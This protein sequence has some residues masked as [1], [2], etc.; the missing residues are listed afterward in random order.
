MKNCPS[1]Q[2]G[3]L[4]AGVE[5]VVQHFLVGPHAETKLAVLPHLARLAAFAGRRDTADVLLPSLLTFFNSQSWQ[6]GRGGCRVGEGLAGCRELACLWHAPSPAHP[7]L[8]THPPQCPP[9][10]V[11]AAFY[12]AFVGVCP[13][14]G[15]EGVAAI[16]LPFLDR[17]VGDP[18]PAVVAEAIQ[19]LA[20]ICSDGLLRKRHILLVAARLCIRPVL[21]PAAPTPVRAAAV[22]FL[23]A[24]AGQLSAAD[25]QA[26]LLPLA[27]PHLAAEP[28]SFA[29]RQGHCVP[30]D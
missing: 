5:R 21:G 16:V 12:S 8:Q 30:V 1:L 13:S 27:L 23:A 26:Q 20:R 14:L 9:L 28:L 10:Q 24:A 7:R 18:E 25:I 22:A 6:V 11:R 3:H 15:P 19:Y 17:L 29:V 2:M 4:R